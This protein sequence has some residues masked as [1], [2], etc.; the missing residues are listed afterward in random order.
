MP[1]EPHNGIACWMDSEARYRYTMRDGLAYLY[2]DGQGREVPGRFLVLRQDDGKVVAQHVNE[3]G[4]ADRIGGLWYLIGNKI[5]AR[6][7]ANHGPRHGGRHP[8]MLWRISGSEIRRLPGSLDKNEFTNAYEVTMEYPVVA[9]CLLE[10][11]E[12]GRVVCYDL[13]AK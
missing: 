7:N 9:G 6:W 4:E 1:F 12:D 2:T 3:D 13:R 8:W 5:I 10:R 11:S